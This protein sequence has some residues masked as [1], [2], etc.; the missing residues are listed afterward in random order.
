MPG[1]AIMPDPMM[2]AGES[3]IAGTW[4]GTLD[5]GAQP[6]KRILVH[7]STEGDGSL[8]GTIDYPDES[9]SGI[10]I[11]AIHYKDPTLHFESSSMQAAY[12][13]TM[14]KD[15]SVITGTWKQGGAT[16]SLTL[17]RVP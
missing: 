12:D 11:T 13:G 14:N 15:S 2:A 1:L 9:I 6:K 7:I 16:L 10:G 3:L 17:K 8:S 4:E 5:P